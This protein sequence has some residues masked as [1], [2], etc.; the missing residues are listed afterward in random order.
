[1]RTFFTKPLDVTISSLWNAIDPAYRKAFFF[2]VLIN[3]LAFGF[4]MTNLTLTHDDIGQILIQ[5]QILGHWLGRFGQG[6]LYYIGHNHHFMPFLQM[7]EAIV[8]MAIY[9]LVIC[10][11]WGV[12]NTLD[13]VLISAILTVFPY[14]AQIYSYNTGTATYPIAHLLAAL[15]VS[16]SIRATFG[17]VAAAAVLYLAAF[18]IYQSVIANAA[19]IFIFWVL[20]RLFVEPDPNKL[21]FRSIVRS[22]L[23]ALLAVGIGGLIYVLIVLS[24]N[25][26]FPTEH[27][28]EKA[29][30]IKGGIDISFALS[31]VI[32]GTRAFLFWPQA[33]FP[34]Y[35]KTI[36]LI[37][38]GC[39]AILCLMVPKKIGTKIAAIV[40]L[41]FSIFAPRL[42]QILHPEG[43]YHALALTAYAVV[44]GG[45]VMLVTKAG[46]S[47]LRNLSSVLVVVLI[48][49]YIMQC[50]WISTVN[51]LNTQAHYSTMT[52]ILART[53]SLPAE[54]WDG[55][56]L[57]VVGSYKMS[58]DYPFRGA[59]GV[60]REYITS[61]HFRRF[62]RLLRDEIVVLRPEE[63]PPSALH[64]AATHEPWPHPSSASVVDGVA[65]VIL[66]KPDPGANRQNSEDT[67][68]DQ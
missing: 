56:K 63:A 33:Y 59:T 3:V 12:K 19:T 44:I 47:I 24:L 58:F 46:S 20:F 22:A 17:A 53:R 8:I 5:D 40:I 54:G 35:L 32:R 55:K 16:L 67:G 42:L 13:L 26:D 43:N 64:Y 49:G 7:A 39:V 27:N 28:V 25:I 15:A 61:H 66:S 18:S 34:D 37:F 52:Q 1:M 21:F 9:G 31:E 38:I 10:R 36:Q 60:A 68:S 62:T 30:S 29:F 11:L 41:G 23:A 50:N 51:Y 6:W 65:V 48:A 45:L 14:M 57:V 4:E 2:I